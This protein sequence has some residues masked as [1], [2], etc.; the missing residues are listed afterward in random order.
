LHPFVV[1][2]LVPKH[3]KVNFSLAIYAT[4]RCVD[5]LHDKLIAASLDFES[6]HLLPDR[7]TRG[8]DRLSGSS[9][10]FDAHD[11]NYLARGSESSALDHLGCQDAVQHDPVLVDLLRGRDLF[12]LCEDVPTLLR[13]LCSQ[14]LQLLYTLLDLY[15]LLEILVNKLIE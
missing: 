11:Y 1:L 13:V 8:C 3:V 15:L 10:S 7:I 6:D 2:V 12:Q 4:C 9:L 5:E 14:V